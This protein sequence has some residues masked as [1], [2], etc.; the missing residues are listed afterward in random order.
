MRQPGSVSPIDFLRY[1]IFV[2]DLVL[3]RRADALPFT[4]DVVWNVFSAGYAT[5]VL[6]QLW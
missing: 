3:V 2:A 5:I 6:F 1:M 4:F